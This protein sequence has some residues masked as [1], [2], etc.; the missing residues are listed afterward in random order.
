MKRNRSHLSIAVTCLILGVLGGSYLNDRLDGQQPAAELVPP[1]VMPREANSLAP[2]VERVLP[3][4]VSIEARGPERDRD[5]DDSSIGFGSGFIVDAAGIVLTNHH[6]VESARQAEVTLSDGRTF[7]STAI[8]KDEKTDLAV[9]KINPKGELPHLTLGDS[10]KMQVGDA[11]LAVGAPFGLTGSVTHGIVSAKSRN[12][13]L[14][15]YEDFLQTDAAINP[16]N[17]G[18]PLVNMEGRVIGITSAIKSRSGGFN[19][20]G[21]A[22]SSKLAQEVMSKLLKDGQVKRGFLGV[23][24][25]DLEGDVAQRLGV[26]EGKG[27]IVTKVEGNSPASAAGLK[28]GDVITTVAGKGV[29]STRVVAQMIAGLPIGQPTEM[30][31]VRQGQAFRTEVTL[32]EQAAEREVLRPDPPVI[33]ENDGPVQLGDF[34][35]DVTDLTPELAKQLR[36]GGTAEGVLIVDVTFGGLAQRAGL[37]KGEIITQVDGTAVKTA[38]QFAAALAKASPEKGALLAVRVPEGGLDYKLIGVPKK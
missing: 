17:S 10:E 21:L 25:R 9:I 28:E 38:A 1:P 6:V 15:Q 12:L 2:V 22:I 32:I 18:G 19:G 11:V 29:D 3:A 5:R 16:G 26:P 27:V 7:Y 31:F 23:I 20:V 14:N 34:G 37:E 30:I 36:I 13:R 33:T 24:I 8:L 4:V 35:L